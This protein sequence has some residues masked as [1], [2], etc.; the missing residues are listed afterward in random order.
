MNPRCR[1]PGIHLYRGLIFPTSLT[2]TRH[3]SIVAES[4]AREGERMPDRASEANVTSI[5]KSNRWSWRFEKSNYSRD[6]I[7]GQSVDPQG[8]SNWI[9]VRLLPEDHDII[10]AN[11]LAENGRFPHR[12][13]QEF[14][15]DSIIHNLHYWWMKLDEWT[16]ENDA[17]LADIEM[18][19]KMV[20]KRHRR[21]WVKQMVSEIDA[22]VH[23]YD[24]RN[25]PE[26]ALEHLE[27]LREDIVQT[28]DDSHRAYIRK[29]LDTR[30]KELRKALK[31]GR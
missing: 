4:Y 27:E 18:A 3:R 23:D 6:E 21:E 19:Q 1:S 24:D 17:Y 16:P 2:R 11:V 31:S 7:Y 29:Y 26:Q 12:S 22:I 5:K 25:E 9:R 15:R 30:A 20:R 8:H 14:L 10:A 13:I 28:D